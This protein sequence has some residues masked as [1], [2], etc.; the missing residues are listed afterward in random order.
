MYKRIE[1]AI[2][3]NDAINSPPISS[4]FAPQEVKI[5]K[6]IE[7]QGILKRYGMDSQQQGKAF[8]EIKSLFNG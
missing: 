6:D 4:L 7:L 3:F 5:N 8:A 2:K 1:E